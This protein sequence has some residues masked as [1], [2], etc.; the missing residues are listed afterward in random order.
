MNNTNLQ[1]LKP[2]DK[3]E[4]GWTIKKI[5]CASKDYL[6]FTTENGLRAKYKEN[7]PELN[8]NFKQILGLY[9]E[10]SALQ[11][12]S[13]QKNE[14][15]NLRIART[16]SYA[17]DGD[18]E[19]SDTI[20]R[21]I[22]KELIKLRHIKSVTNYIFTCLIAF[23][24]NVLAAIICF[25]KLYPP[26]LKLS[27]IIYVSSFGSLGALLS[28]LISIRKLK[29]DIESPLYIN[30]VWGGVRILIGMAASI[31]AYVLIRADLI[32]GTI[33]SSD[34]NFLI[35]SLCTLAGFSE[36]YIPNILKGIPKKN[37]NNIINA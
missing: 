35:Y 36:K 4:H 9:S 1:N 24:L 23:I 31:I 21:D 16:I 7:K 15:L 11:T 14:S 37:L 32:L 18:I 8:S 6:I 33:N 27:E 34:N 12:G 30:I 3:I 28:V 13:F 5:Y 2:G 22:K 19:K 26:L 25:Y 29:M 17:F 20:L 10:I